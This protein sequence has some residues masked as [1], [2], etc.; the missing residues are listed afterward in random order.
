MLI[1]DR[2]FWTEMSEIYLNT[3]SYPEY[4]LLFNN[5][6]EEMINL[7]RKIDGRYWNKIALRY[8]QMNSLR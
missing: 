7:L 5:I 2:I 3:T 1:C 4:K 8:V 6:C